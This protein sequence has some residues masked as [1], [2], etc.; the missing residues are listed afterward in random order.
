VDVLGF[1]KKW[2]P[3]IRSAQD[4]CDAA[5]VE[6]D[7]R[8]IV[9]AWR[10]R[11]QEIFGR[12]ASESVGQRVD[13]L[14][15]SQALMQSPDAGVA[16]FVEVTTRD[17]RVVSCRM[18]QSVVGNRT[19]SYFVD[20]TA[21]RVA[22]QAACERKRWES[23]GVVAGGTA[24]SFN[25]LLTGVIGHAT[26]LLERMPPTDRA[27]PDLEAIVDCGERAAEIA[28]RM[29]DYSGNGQFFPRDVDMNRTIATA[30]GRVR[31]ILGT[32]IET[33]SR[34]SPRSLHIQGDERQLEDLVT[35][36]IMNS[37]EAIG[38]KPGR[39]ELGIVSEKL[40]APVEVSTGIL[41]PAAY[42]KLR[43]R[44]NGCGM[45]AATRARMF[46]PFFS[47]KFVGRGLGLAAA[48]G[49]A[50]GHAGGIRVESH[51]GRGTTIDVYLKD[52]REGVARLTFQT[53]NSG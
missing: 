5:V 25:N 4:A 35:A 1:G 50:R 46:D 33:S 52:L 41:E 17:G 44:D 38:D 49:I 40:E 30:L 15:F 2:R 10:G 48:A 51:V 13:R 22:D 18:R 36:L 14:G 32:R 28:R 9:T 20:V 39:I 3:G 19:R 45:D 27:R 7:A 6:W 21:E 26:L 24:H 8:L 12:G 16:R 29:L 37:V 43:I 42:L 53:G 34:Y 31:P 11:A 23:L 47:T